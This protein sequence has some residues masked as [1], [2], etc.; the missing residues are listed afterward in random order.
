MITHL[1]EAERTG[2]P[3]YQEIYQCARSHMKYHIALLYEKDED[4][5][6]RYLNSARGTVVHY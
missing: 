2:S 3:D 5:K 6:A 1:R 4:D